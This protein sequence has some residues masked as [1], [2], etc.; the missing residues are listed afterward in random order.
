MSK[1]LGSGWT[2]VADAPLA[3]NPASWVCRH[4]YLGL[5]KILLPS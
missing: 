4:V 3:G 1:D 2:R 5:S